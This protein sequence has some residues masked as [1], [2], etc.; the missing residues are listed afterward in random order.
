MYDLETLAV[1]ITLRRQQLDL[2][3]RQL[4]DKACL[5]PSTISEA[6]SGKHYLRS[7]KLVAIAKA[8]DCTVDDLLS[9]EAHD[10][11]DIRWIEIGRR[12]TRRERLR[13]MEYAEW[14]YQ[15]QREQNDIDDDDPDQGVVDNTNAS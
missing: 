6:E 8:L 9:I 10:N 3:M 14:R 1:N 15:L 7:D 12:L 5:S 13:V 11:K 4:A 2:S